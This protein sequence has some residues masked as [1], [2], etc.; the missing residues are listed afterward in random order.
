MRCPCSKVQAP[1][2]VVPAPAN[3]WASLGE[4]LSSDQCS[5]WAAAIGAAN[6]YVSGGWRPGHACPASPMDS[7][8]REGSAASLAWL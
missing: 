7:H 8:S 1:A 2:V 4:Y 5:N 3:G 6:N